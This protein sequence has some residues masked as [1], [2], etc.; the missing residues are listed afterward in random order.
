M[1]LHENTSVICLDVK[2]DAYLHA[3]TADITEWVYTVGNTVGGNGL[4][5]L[6]LEDI[7]CQN[8]ML[9]LKNDGSWSAGPHW[10]LPH[11]GI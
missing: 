6:H 3:I 2:K 1:Y 10:D 4:E 11:A 9:K 8:I 5:K 7:Q